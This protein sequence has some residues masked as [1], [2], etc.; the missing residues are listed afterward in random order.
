MDNGGTE[1]RRKLYRGSGGTK[2]SWN[3][4]NDTSRSFPILP[5]SFPSLFFETIAARLDFL[6]QPLHEISTKRNETKF[7]KLLPNFFRLSIVKTQTSPPTM[8]YRPIKSRR[9]GGCERLSKVTRPT[10]PFDEGRRKRCLVQRTGIPKFPLRYRCFSLSLS[11]SLS[12][13]KLPRSLDRTKFN[14]DRVGIT[15]REKLSGGKRGI[16]DQTY[17]NSI[18]ERS[19]FLDRQT[20]RQ[21]EKWISKSSWSHYY[22]RFELGNIIYRGQRTV[23]RAR[24][25]W[26]VDA[27]CA[28]VSFVIVA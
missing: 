16:D 9:R 5:P 8:K 4:S 1:N 21:R 14:P 22:T 24:S 2:E 25:N 27:S 26:K 20:D 11:L 15:R 17:A 13:E 28:G 23:K 7:S 6:N 18:V 12:L 10:R 19:S 3:K